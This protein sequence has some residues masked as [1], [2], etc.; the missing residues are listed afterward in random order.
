MLKR[1]KFFWLIVVVSGLFMFA[2]CNGG[3]GEESDNSDTTEV[4]GDNE[5]PTG[6]LA[7]GMTPFDFPTVDITANAGDYILTPGY[8]M[9][10]NSLKTEE[11]TDET[12]IFYAYEM[13]ESGKVES[14]I[15]FT[16][17]GEQMMPNSM[18][19]PIPQG[20]TA[21]VGDVVLTWWQSGSGICRAIVTDASNPS[22]PTVKY[23]DLDLDNEEEQLKPNSFVKLTSDW[24]PG[25]IIAA[26]G[27]YDYVAAQ[28]IR[29]SGN[30]VLTL[31]FAG[32]IVVYDKADCKPVPI[33]PD[34]KVGDK[35]WATFVD[36]FGE[37]EVAKID[38]KMVVYM[39]YNLTNL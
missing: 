5:V 12:Y 39:L 3:G 17:D 18:M 11:P 19:I 23:L 29:V 37:Y 7:A 9:Y 27:E 10:Q 31:G 1:S 26:K 8:E 21:E 20:Q 28:I 2:S 22:E 38:K 15:S 30:K 25:N 24:Q 16:F 35:V 14:K 36:A 6:E 13:L 32:R 34:V 33:T 4:A